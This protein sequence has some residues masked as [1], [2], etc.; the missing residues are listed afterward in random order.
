MS[1]QV[2]PALGALGIEPCETALA[3]DAA[4]QVEIADRLAHGARAAVQHQPQAV[5]L[6]RLQLDE[7][8][9][10]AERAELQ[11]SLALLQRLERARAER[12]GVELGRQAV[13]PLARVA[14]E[15]D[16]SIEAGQHR[17]RGALVVE[18]RGLGV[19]GDGRHAAPDVSADRGGVEG[20]ARG[21]HRADAHVGRQV[22]VR[23][24]GDPPDV[25]APREALEGQL[26]VAWERSVGPAADRRREHQPRSTSSASRSSNTISGTRLRWIDRATSARTANEQPASAARASAMPSGLAPEARHTTILS[27]PASGAG[28]T[29]DD[30]RT[31]ERVALALARQRQRRRALAPACTAAAPS[32]SSSG[33]VPSRRRRLPGP[34][35]R[36]PTLRPSAGDAAPALYVKTHALL[37]RVRANAQSPPDRLGFLSWGAWLSTE[38]AERA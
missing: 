28:S 26:H 5:R 15:R 10:A 38:P 13:R 21:D 3:R 2:V 20:A 1:A 29:D 7:M 23:H 32:S 27:R 30:R 25:V 4:A 31:G 36:P 37:W 14:Y 16:G 33:N 22:D 8:V 19:E 18:H 24:H 9:A 35:R 11:R 12:L 6:V 34:L 17:G